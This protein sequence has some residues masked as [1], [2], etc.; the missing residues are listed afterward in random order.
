VPALAWFELQEPAQFP[1]NG[2]PLD[3]FV[4]WQGEGPGP[5]EG[6]GEWVIDRTMGC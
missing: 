6:A 3:G 1:Q 2:I 4:P 5:F